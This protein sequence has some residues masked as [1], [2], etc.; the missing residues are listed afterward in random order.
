MFANSRPSAS[1]FNFFS[2]SLEQ[3]FLTQVRTILVTKY[4]F[5]IVWI[6]CTFLPDSLINKHALLVF[7]DFFHQTFSCIIKEK[8]FHV[9]NENNIPIYS[10]IMACLF[11]SEFRVTEFEISCQ[12]GKLFL[13]FRVKM[14]YSL[15]HVYSLFLQKVR[16]AEIK[17]FN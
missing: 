9:I 5:S 12:M 11:I 10:F 6:L 17:D 13:L 16:S 7:V 15:K 8:K 4:R 14:F 2:R 1:N 3:F